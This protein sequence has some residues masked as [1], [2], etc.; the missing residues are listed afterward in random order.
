MD[1]SGA[2]VSVTLGSLDD[3]AAFKPVTHDGIEE[4]MPWFFELPGV[5]DHGE[6]KQPSQADW[7][8][9]IKASNRQHPDHDTESWP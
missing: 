9:A 7:V 4:R 8:A 1:V 3:P 6:T 2:H 5:P